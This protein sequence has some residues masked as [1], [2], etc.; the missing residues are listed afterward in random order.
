MTHKLQKSLKHLRKLRKS[1][2][3]ARSIPPDSQHDAEL[4]TNEDE[5]DLSSSTADNSLLHNA[6]DNPSQIPKDA[7]I[8]INEDL[9]RGR[10]FMS[11]KAR[12]IKNA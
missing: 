10:A 11:Y 5:S 2:R 6:T 7:V 12:C 9:W 1:K 8:Y 4:P 3:V